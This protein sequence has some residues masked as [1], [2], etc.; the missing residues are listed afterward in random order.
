MA[1]WCN[2]KVTFNGDKD[3]LNKVLALFKEMIEKESKG[4]IGQLPDFIES[5]NGYFFEIYCDETDE[6]SFHYETRW[7]PNIESL[8]MVATHYNVGFVLDY[9]ESG[10][11]VYGKTIY[12]NEILQDYF[13]NQCDFQDCIYNV[14]TDCYEFEGT[15]YDYQDEI[16]R[17][18]LDRKINNNKQK[19]A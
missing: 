6:C 3:S 19:I 11:M 1:N 18:L 16:M 15:S 14:D 10:C 7:S 4:N 17:I 2:N 13:L 5:K 12:E 8:W 9:E